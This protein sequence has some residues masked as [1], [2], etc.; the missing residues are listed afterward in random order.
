MAADPTIHEVDHETAIPCWQ[1]ARTR[2]LGTQRKR[3]QR[4]IIFGVLWAVVITGVVL[5]G[6]LMVL[7]VFA[8][9]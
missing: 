4:R 6:G 3:S 1:Q 7:P 2:A 9:Y 5:L 8:G